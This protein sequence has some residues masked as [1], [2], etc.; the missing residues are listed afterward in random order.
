[1]GPWENLRKARALSHQKNWSASAKFFRRSMLAQG[2]YQV[3]LASERF[4]L[5]LERVPPL[6][7]R[8]IA[9]PLP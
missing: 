1:M 9:H 5:G 7:L 6:F 2:A 4:R 3:D 8:P